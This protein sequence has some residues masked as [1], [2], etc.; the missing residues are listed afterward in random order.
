M[1]LFLDSAL[2]DE[3][4]AALEEWDVDGVTTNPRHV[5]AAGRPLHALLRD[6]ARLV[7]GTDKPVSVEVNPHLTDWREIVREARQLAELSPNFV[8]KIGAGEAGFRAASELSRLG[9]RTNVTLV[10]SVAQAWHAARSGAAYVS[11][12]IGWKE[13]HGD[14]GMQ[15]VADVAQLLHVQDYPTQVIAAAVRNAQHIAAAALAG[16]HCVTAGAGVIRDS[17]RNPYTDL[18]VQVFGDAW[19]RTPPGDG[20]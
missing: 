15:L 13:T 5:A 12:F 20:G 2:P 9:V 1:L 16:A 8:V 6:I 10:F 14:D 7:E 19:N 17:F 3:I 4:A 11:P 18:G